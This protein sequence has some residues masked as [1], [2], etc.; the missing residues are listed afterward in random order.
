MGTVR[1]YIL[2][3]DATAG[4]KLTDD[5][6]R[7]GDITEG[8]VMT[9]FAAGD[10][11]PEPTV[12]PHGRLPGKLAVVASDGLWR[13]F[14]APGDLATQLPGSAFTDAEEAAIRLS[15]ATRAAGGRDD[16]TVAVLALTPEADARN[17]AGDGSGRGPTGVRRG[18]EIPGA[19]QAPPGAQAQ[20]EAASEPAVAAQMRRW[21]RH[22]KLLRSG[23]AGGRLFTLLLLGTVVALVL[24]AEPA[25][26]AMAGVLPWGAAAA[27]P[28]STASTVGGGSAKGRG[29]IV[30]SNHPDEPELSSIER[31]RWAGQLRGLRLRLPGDG[32]LARVLHI[33]A[34]DTAAL[35]DGEGWDPTWPDPPVVVFHR[36]AGARGAAGPGWATA[37]WDGATLHVVATGPVDAREALVE[38]V[39]G[40]WAGFEPHQAQVA[41]VVAGAVVAPARVRPAGPASA[42]DGQRLR[43]RLEDLFADWSVW[44]QLVLAHADEV[45]A[46]GVLADAQ[47]QQ[48]RTAPADS[49][50]WVRRLWGWLDRQVT[51]P[52]AGPP[53]QDMR[54]VA[55][56]LRGL[57]T[58]R[59]NLMPENYP[60]ELALAQRHGITRARLGTDAVMELARLQPTVKGVVTRDGEVWLIPKVRPGGRE[61]GVEFSHAFA[62]AGRDV[63]VAFTAE[64]RLDG[65]QLVVADLSNWS[66]HYNDGNTVQENWRVI[67]RATTVFRMHGIRVHEVQAEIN[68][69][70]GGFLAP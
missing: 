16:Y 38:A 2:T 14:R 32:E 47:T 45:H 7:G 23:L 21:K 68:A 43:R 64:L 33:W 24:W 54:G 5:H 12:T 37:H 3:A 65:D 55:D 9:R 66:G 34:E 70:P 13:Y 19:P 20:A 49:R 15:D 6:T 26:V 10:F 39:F 40:R 60:A 1:V 35:L 44:Q 29:P 18:L 11:Q 67:H 4:R 25:T 51:R 8:G 41:A 22:W 17:P 57:A 50:G 28:G 63:Q 58:P 52:R 42:D 31:R 30:S 53:G 48:R 46:A 36:R 27:M 62:A 59:P 56:R 69:M 61:D